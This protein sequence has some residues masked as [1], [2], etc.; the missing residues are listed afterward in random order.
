MDLITPDLGLFFWHTII[1]LAVLLVLAKYAWRP[2]L[3]AIKNREKSIEMSLKGAEKARKEFERLKGDNEKLILQA[4]EDRDQLLKD[5]MV[6]ANEMKDKA[7]EEAATA[8]TKIIH[9]AQMAIQK[10]K[11]AAIRDIKEKVA[12]IS[13]EIA[14]KLLRQQL[15]DAASQKKLIDSYLKDVKFN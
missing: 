14:E 1:F 12:E 11:D 3:G 7:R 13:I 8:A 4:K 9:D 10:E 15:S 5:A 6:I 2:I